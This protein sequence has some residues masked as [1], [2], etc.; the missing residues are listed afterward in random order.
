MRLHSLEG[1]ILLMKDNQSMQCADCALKHL[2]LA[3]SLGKEILSG[4]G[5]DG[6]PDHRPDFL[7]ELV[8]AEHHL[9]VTYNLFAEKVRDFRLSLQSNIYMPTPLDLDNLRKLW[10]SIDEQAN[11]IDVVAANNLIDAP[12]ELGSKY[13]FIIDAHW[14]RDRRELLTSLIAQNSDY[15]FD[16]LVDEVVD[17]KTVPDDSKIWYL[18]PDVFPVRHFDL[19]RNGLFKRGTQPTDNVLTFNT[20]DFKIR[21]S[22]CKATATLGDVINGM[23]II[24]NEEQGHDI[25]ELW[26]PPCCHNLRRFKN[27]S[28]IFVKAMSDKVLP[29]IESTLNR[30]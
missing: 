24:N 11:E 16:I 25:T 6:A 19:S 7:G 15:D 12:K 1:L 23:E 8:N 27:G 26:E 29:W 22:A 2:A 17:W 30:K 28:L 14:R 20:K 4:H 21:L 3:I 10:L 18:P 5:K 13:F 9:S